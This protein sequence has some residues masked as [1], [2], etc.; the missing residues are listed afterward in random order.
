MTRIDIRDL[1]DNLR[2]ALK[3]ASAGEDVVLTDGAAARA[4]IVPIAEIAG[5]RI[6][7]LH[8]GSIEV[9]DNFDEP[10]PDEFW[11]GDE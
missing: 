8:A 11:A 1:P 6:A 9:A 2:E 10:L 3:L 4:R 7:G 5:K